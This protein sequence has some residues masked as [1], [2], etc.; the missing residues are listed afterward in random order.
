V[1]FLLLIIGFKD[2]QFSFWIDFLCNAFLISALAA[3]EMVNLYFQPSILWHE[4][5]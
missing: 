3:I 4:V 1:F 5:P 2:Q